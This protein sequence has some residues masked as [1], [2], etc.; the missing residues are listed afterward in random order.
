MERASRRI[1]DLQ[2]IGLLKE[3]LAAS[4]QPGH[5]PHGLLAPLLA[6]I[7]FE[8]I[9]HIL[10]QAR[11]LG[12]EGNCL[13]VQCTRVANQLVVLS[14]RDPRYDWILPAVQKR[15]R[16]E[17]SQLHYDPAAVETQ[18]LDVTCGEPLCFLGFE[19]HVVTGRRGEARVHYQR[20]KELARSQP[21]GVLPSRRRQGRF[22]P[23]RFVR[24]CVSWMGRQ[25][26]WQFVHAA[27]RQVNA[28]QVGW[29]HLPI[30]LCPVLLLLFSWRS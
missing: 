2:L 24:H 25:P 7:A 6:D 3:V 23:L 21:E 18:S 1:G 10:Q 29:R 5:P 30:T 26:C 12:R 28:I 19:L 27:Y 11:T 16:E 22:H 20:M 13:H 9:D 4:A 8:G 15:L 14:D 17:L